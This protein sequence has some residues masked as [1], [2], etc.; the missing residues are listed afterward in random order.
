VVIRPADLDADSRGRLRRNTTSDVAVIGR[1]LARASDEHRVT[2][3]FR[4][5]LLAHGWTPVAPTSRRSGTK[6]A[7]SA[8]PRG[9]PRSPGI[10]A[11][12]AYDQLLR[13]MTSTSGDVRYALIVPTSSTRAAQ[14][15][16]QHVRDLLRITVYA[17]ADDGQ[18]RQL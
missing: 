15:V 6:S 16:P 4:V 14:R 9:R 7:S 3:A 10:D 8:R 18:V 5:W 17:V 2:D 1:L 11:D 13:R 12:I